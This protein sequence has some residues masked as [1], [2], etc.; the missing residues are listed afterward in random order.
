MRHAR[1]NA[2][3]LILVS[4]KRGSLTRN[5][6]ISSL[7]LL[8]VFVVWLL[9]GH[10]VV[11]RMEVTLSSPVSHISGEIQSSFKSCARR[12]RKMVN[13][14]RVPRVRPTC[15]VG[16]LIGTSVQV[17]SSWSRVVGDQYAEILE[18]GA[19]ENI[20]YMHPFR[21]MRFETLTTY[22]PSPR[23]QKTKRHV[24]TSHP[25][26]TAMHRRHTKRIPPSK[27]R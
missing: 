7:V 20:R 26:I 1:G 18:L 15:G 24:E 4:G 25:T 22:T 5:R 3:C 21:G 11:Y 10:G 19:S 9:F 16:L 17:S 13:F 8:L 14:Y 27:E 6:R 12:L 2:F 23:D